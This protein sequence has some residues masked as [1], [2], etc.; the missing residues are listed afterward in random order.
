MLILKENSKNHTTMSKSINKMGKKREKRGCQQLN[1][2]QRTGTLKWSI[3]T[4]HEIGIFIDVDYVV[5]FIEYPYV[6]KSEK[7]VREEYR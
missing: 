2:P 4:N 3:Y 5:V 1:T 6:C 7:K